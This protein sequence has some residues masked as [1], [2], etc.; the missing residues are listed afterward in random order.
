MLA[1]FKRVFGSVNETSDGKIYADGWPEAISYDRSKANV[2]LGH[3]A[4]GHGITEQGDADVCV[5]LEDA[6]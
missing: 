1:E 6:R 2:I 3:F 5:R 4:D